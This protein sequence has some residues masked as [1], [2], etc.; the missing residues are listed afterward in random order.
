M[1]QERTVQAS[2][3]DLFAGQEIP[4]R[5]PCR[6]LA[7]LLEGWLLGHGP[8]FLTSKAYPATSG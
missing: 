1:R 4:V 8:D 2:I 3:F 7:R 5:P 6:P